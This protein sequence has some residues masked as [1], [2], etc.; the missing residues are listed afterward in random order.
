M[1]DKDVCWILFVDSDARWLD[2]AVGTLK[3]RRI[4]ARGV[5][6]ISKVERASKFMLGPQLA[7][8]DLEF[9]ERAPDQL[10][11]FAKHGNKYVVVLFPTCTSSYR[12]SRIFKLG[13]YDCVDKPYDVQS[14]MRLVKSLSEEIG[15]STRDATSFLARKY[16]PAA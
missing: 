8:V 14:L 6:D 11:H 12:M 4:R 7:F 16:V 9:A 10:Q 1:S 5:T 3:E 15:L 2:F 13:A